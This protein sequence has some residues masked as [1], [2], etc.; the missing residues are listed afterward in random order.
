MIL[1][2]YD[3]SPDG[4]AAIDRIAQIL[5]AS[6]A[7]VLT[8]WQPYIALVGDPTTGLGWDLHTPIDTGPLDAANI[9]AAHAT[10]EDGV[11]RA[12]RAGLE[13]EPHVRA[14]ASTTAE[15]ILTTADELGAEL[16]VLGTR[17]RTG[18][19]SLLLGSVSHAVL[20]HADR[21]VVVIPSPVVAKERRAHTHRLAASPPG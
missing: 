14:G 12:Q 9:A 2:A 3:G 4:G 6:R 1:I 8:V 20:Q 21:P 18:L 10:A 13:A 16:I 17:G 11:A 19:R 7:A 15:T 5:P